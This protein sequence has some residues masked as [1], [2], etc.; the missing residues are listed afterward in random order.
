M[1]QGDRRLKLS[2]HP[3][4]QCSPESFRKDTQGPILLNS[5]NAPNHI[6]NSYRIRVDSIIK[7]Y[8]GEHFREF[9]VLLAARLKLPAQKTE[10]GF[11]TVVRATEQRHNR[12]GHI[13]VVIQRPGDG[14]EPRTRATITHG[15]LSKRRVSTLHVG[16][17]L[18]G[19]L[20]LRTCGSPRN[21][22]NPNPDEAGAVGTLRTSQRPSLS[23]ACPDSRTNMCCPRPGNDIYPVWFGRFTGRH[24]L[25]QWPHLYGD[26]ECYRG[27]C[28]VW[29]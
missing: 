12:D 24:R 19:R 23:K 13:I 5:G 4:D 10:E 2:P 27:D 7:A 3:G 20:P 22:P 28:V 14:Q 11:D 18:L 9:H 1:R 29:G 25:I 8:W 15:T 26:A 6:R 16:A 21:S 17:L